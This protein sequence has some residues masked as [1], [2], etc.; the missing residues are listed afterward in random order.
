MLNLAGAT[1]NEYAEGKINKI[2]IAK[3]IL[4]LNPFIKNKNVELLYLSSENFTKL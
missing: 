3:K 1:P 2:A 4:H